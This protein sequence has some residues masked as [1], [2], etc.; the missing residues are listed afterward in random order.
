M[1]SKIGFYTGLCWSLS[2]IL[3]MLSLTQ[4][5][6]GFAGQLLGIGSIWVAGWQLRM[7]Q[8]AAVKEDASAL[9]GVRQRWHMSLYAQLLAALLC[10]CVQYLY[11]R[12][13]DNGEML[14][15]MTDVYTNPANAEALK[16]MMPEFDPKE[17]IAM[18][19]QISLRELTLNFMVMNA[20]VALMLS[21]PTAMV[22]RQ[23]KK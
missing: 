5:A 15:V 2:F 23:R 18:L 22:A 14:R 17:T 7:W 4:P 11:F 9:W 20:F 12:Y 10:T 1:L 19:S 21:L 13:V 8:A 3:V 6:W 16:Q